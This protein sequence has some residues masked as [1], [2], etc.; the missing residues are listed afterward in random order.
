MYT[1]VRNDVLLLI[2]TN[3]CQFFF[4]CNSCIVGHWPAG[5][6]W[7]SGHWSLD[8]YVTYVS[9]IASVT[10]QMQQERIQLKQPPLK[11]VWINPFN[12]GSFRPDCLQRF[13]PSKDQRGFYRMK[14]W[15]DHVGSLMR[16]RGIQVIE[17]NEF[18]APWVRESPDCAHFHT[19]P[20]KSA[21][22]LLVLWTLCFANIYYTC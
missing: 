6:D 11:F 4:F 22:E 19:T 21:S 2:L 14:V 20:G 15:S 8:R 5:G 1:C 13:Q 18:T 3:C 17:G 12:S 9:Y 7:Q 16:S 10:T